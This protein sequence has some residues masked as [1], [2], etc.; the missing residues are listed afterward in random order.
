MMII[1]AA[2]QLQGTLYVSIESASTQTGGSAYQ[3]FATF[4]STRASGQKTSLHLPDAPWSI[5]GSSKW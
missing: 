3:N 4:A 2:Q 5:Y 1:Y